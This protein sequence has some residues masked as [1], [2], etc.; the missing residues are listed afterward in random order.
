MHNIFCKRIATLIAVTGPTMMAADVLGV[1]GT[2]TK[3]LAPASD[4]STGSPTGGY[5][6]PK[7]GIVHDPEIG[8]G[9]GYSKLDKRAQKLGQQDV[10]NI[11]A[12]ADG[13][14]TDPE[15]LAQG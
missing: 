3:A 14:A 7:R 2:P 11:D 12:Y 8:I 5:A 13:T 9:G 4:I 6:D 10:D 1:T 15:R